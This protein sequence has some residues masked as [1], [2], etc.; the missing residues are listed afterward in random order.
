MII[1]QLSA[2]V[3]NKKDRLS[4]IICALGE[5]NID[6]SSLSL[7][8]TTDYGVLRL[9]LNKTDE[10]KKVLTEMG[11]IVKVVD[12]IAVAADDVPGGVAKVLKTIS[13]N[14]INIDYAYACVGKTA[15]KALMVFRTD[16]T[17]RAEEILQ[18]TGF[19]AIN[20]EDIYRI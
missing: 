3:E 7:A 4:A 9:I 13:E 17:Q 20:P 12:V 16:E 8:D 1:K 6:I 14:D 15:G 5:N 10:A 2:F 18:K 19:G 11:I